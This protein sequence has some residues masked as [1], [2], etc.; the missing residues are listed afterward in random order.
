VGW[1][2][3]ASLGDAKE[4]GTR[5]EFD[6][7]PKPKTPQLAEA[8][9]QPRR[10]R[11]K[12]RLVS[13][14]DQTKQQ[15][16]AIDSASSAIV[17]AADSENLGVLS[18]K[19]DALMKKVTDSGSAS[20][21]P[22]PSEESKP[23][24]TPAPEVSPNT[25]TAI[26]A[27]SFPLPSSA[28]QFVRDP[29]RKEIRYTSTAKADVQ[30]EFLQSTLE[31]W[32]W[33][34]GARSQT[35]ANDVEWL[36]LWFNKNDRSLKVEIRYKVNERSGATTISG[37]GLRFPPGVAVPV[38]PPTPAPAPASSLS[39]KDVKGLPVPDASTNLS[40]ESSPYRRSLETAVTSSLDVVV[41][42]YR[43]QMP[44]RG[45]QEA[46]ESK[47]EADQANLVYNGPDSALTASFSRAGGDVKIA[48]VERHPAAAQRDGVAPPAGKARLLLAS[49]A[50]ADATVTINGSPYTVKAGTG[51][52]SPAQS[53]KVD[54][55]PGT[56]KLVV[57]LAGK[58]DQ[59]LDVPVTTGETWGAVILGEGQVFGPLRFY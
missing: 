46:A 2:Y 50:A 55:F 49:Q 48:L 16:E 12:R 41:A 10:R 19:I 58:G 9:S 53:F 34:R 36:D 29:T 47:V 30:G 15:L 22:V 52:Q 51:A 5:V 56:N 32:G 18:N 11:V 17:K 44:G 40:D 21:G 27:E 33:E 20:R 13:K 31:S 35:T 6:A 59:R 42:F 3:A 54:L 7:S 14:E 57:K 38:A 28:Q 26:A 8:P 25:E 1:R 23:A 4:G 24:P 39:A 45:Y 37:D 43:R